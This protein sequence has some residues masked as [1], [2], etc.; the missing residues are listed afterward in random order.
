M[1]WMS[2]CDQFACDD[3]D[4]SLREAS[5]LDQSSNMESSEGGLLRQFHHYAV[6][7]GQGGT[8]FPGL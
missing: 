7:G 6:P 4:N 3:I 2:Q 1:L 8:Q 5:F